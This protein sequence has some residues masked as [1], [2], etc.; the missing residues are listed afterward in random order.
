[1]RSHTNL[2]ATLH[3]S[4]SKRIGKATRER[5]GFAHACRLALA[6]LSTAQGRSR[7]PLQVGALATIAVSLDSLFLLTVLGPSFLWLLDNN[8]D[9]DEDAIDNGARGIYVMLLASFVSHFVVSGMI[10]R[11]AYFM[12][13]LLHPARPAAASIV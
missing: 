6:Q 12:R 5:T 11:K 3:Q 7:C 9:T 2:R 10:V 4:A 13:K 8:D 1:M